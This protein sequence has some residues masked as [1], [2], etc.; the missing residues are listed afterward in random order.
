MPSVTNIGEASIEMDT[1]KLQVTKKIPL[2]KWKK[3]TNPNDDIKFHVSVSTGASE[4]RL[5]FQFYPKG[6]SDSTLDPLALPVFLYATEPEP[7][8]KLAVSWAGRFDQ[9]GGR[10]GPVRLEEQQS[11]HLCVEKRPLK[12]GC[13]VGG[14]ITEHVIGGFVCLSSLLMLVH[15]RGASLQSRGTAVLQH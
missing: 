7:P 15:R 14:Y 5:E 6:C 13:G 1:L 4:T 3:A 10:E 9:E 12:N 2:N 8:R 11:Y